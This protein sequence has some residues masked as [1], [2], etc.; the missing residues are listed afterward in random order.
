MRT[1]SVGS[2]L[3]VIVTVCSHVCSNFHHL[4]IL[5][6]IHLSG[7]YLQWGDY[8]EEGT[9]NHSLP[10]DFGGLG[11]RNLDLSGAS[12]LGISLEWPPPYLPIRP[13]KLDRRIWGGALT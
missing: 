7:A 1:L 8:G 4:A 12:T 13:N 2:Q 9:S 3:L 11:G 5:F 6:S 10:R